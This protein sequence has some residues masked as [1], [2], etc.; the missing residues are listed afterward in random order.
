MYIILETL[1]WLI[2]TILLILK[3]SD[4][5]Y[6]ECLDEAIIMHWRKEMLYPSLLAPK[7]NFVV[8]VGT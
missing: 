8:A 2:I 6:F 4:D 3:I 1:I 7:C 5:H